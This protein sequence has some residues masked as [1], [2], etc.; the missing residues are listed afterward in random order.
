MAYTKVTKT[1]NTNF[2]ISFKELVTASKKLS[3][4]LVASDLDN[5]ADDAIRMQL[6][7]FYSH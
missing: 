4:A 2:F 7:H 6:G 5:P 1:N 3:I